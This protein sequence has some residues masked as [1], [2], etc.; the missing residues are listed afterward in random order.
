MKFLLFY[1]KYKPKHLLICVKTKGVT[2][3]NSK[4]VKQ[5]IEPNHVRKQVFGFP[6]SIPK[7][8][9]YL[10]NMNY[11][12]RT[13]SSYNNNFKIYCFKLLQQCYFARV[14]N[15]SVLTN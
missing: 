10:F 5:I 13:T 15:F 7:V 14:R 4:I 3:Q 6:N 8:D 11:Q 2:M 1:I 9:F 12:C